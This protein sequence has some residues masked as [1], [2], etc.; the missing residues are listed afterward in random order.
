MTL[1]WNSRTES[2]IGQRRLDSL[3]ASWNR[4]VADRASLGQQ[5]PRVIAS[6][7]RPSRDKFRQNFLRASLLPRT[8]GEGRPKD[9]ENGA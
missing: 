2:R 4:S 5:A 9:C 1:L 3:E 6:K 7:A 8:R